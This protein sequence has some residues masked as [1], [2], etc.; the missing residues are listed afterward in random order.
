MLCPMN[1]TTCNYMSH[2]VMTV[3]ATPSP[4]FTTFS[5]TYIMSLTGSRQVGNPCTVNLLHS[6]N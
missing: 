2:M 5:A 3:H 1:Q 4:Y 6:Y